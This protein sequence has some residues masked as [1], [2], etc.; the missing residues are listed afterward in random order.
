MTTTEQTTTRTHWRIETRPAVGG[1][2]VAYGPTGRGWA[3][4]SEKRC[5]EMMTA[6]LAIT[7]VEVLVRKTSSG[8]YCGGSRNGELA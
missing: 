4:V 5:D 8:G 7:P 1:A 2:W 6:I 3:S